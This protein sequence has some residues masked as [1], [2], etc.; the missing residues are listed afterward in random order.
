MLQNRL[1]NVEN[2]KNQEIANL[3]QEIV[4]LRN[5]QNSQRIAKVETSSKP[6]ILTEIQKSTKNTGDISPSGNK[7]LKN[8]AYIDDDSDEKVSLSNHTYKADNPVSN[9]CT[10]MENSVIV[11]HSSKI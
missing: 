5:I 2:L 3:R 8:V 7:S 1:A 11:K 6:V 4:N 9:E 10:L